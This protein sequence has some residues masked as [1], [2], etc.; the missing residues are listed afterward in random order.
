MRGSCQVSKLNARWFY[1]DFRKQ[2]SWMS[3]SCQVSKLH[4]VPSTVA[5]VTF[6]LRWHEHAPLEHPRSHDVRHAVFCT[7]S[8]IPL[9][10]IIPYNTL[11]CISGAGDNLSRTHE[12][13]LSRTQAQNRGKK[14]SRTKRRSKEVLSRWNRR[15]KTALVWTNSCRD[16]LWL[17]F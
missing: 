9:M 1:L 3:V 4:G 17:P 16:S 11:C 7:S 6:F 5:F 10:L 14:I 15:I 13:K 2:H 8:L 12:D